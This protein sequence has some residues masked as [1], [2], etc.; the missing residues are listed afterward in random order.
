MNDNFT[1]L[2]LSQHYPVSQRFQIFT[3]KDVSID[4]D[5]ADYLRSAEQQVSQYVLDRINACASIAVQRST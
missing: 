2:L 5:V 1:L 4:A 3:S